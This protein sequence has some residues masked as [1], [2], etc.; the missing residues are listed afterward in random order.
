MSRLVPS[1]RSDIAPFMAMD[2]LRDARALERAGRRIVHM[3]LGE[4]GAP[5]PRLVREAAEAALRGGRIGYGEALGDAGLRARIAAHY[6]AR[7]GVDVGADRVVVTTGSSGGFM[8]ALLAAFDAGARIAVT[9]PGYPAYA[10]ILASLGLEAVPLPIGPATRFAP[11]AAMLEAAHREKKLDGALFMSPAN[12]TGAVIESEELA[13]ICAFCDEAGVVFVSDEIYHGLEYAAPAET[14]LRFTQSAIVVNSFSKYYA[15][16][17]WR[18]GWLVAPPAFMRPLERL[19]QSLAICAPTISQRA[20]LAAFD[21]TEELQENRAAYARNRALLLEKL[22]AMG[23]DGFAP[24]DGAFYVYADV[25]AFTADSLDFCRNMLHEA[26]VAAT[27]G[28]DFDPERGATTL[29]L[30]Y[31]GAEADIAEGVKRLGAWLSAKPR[32]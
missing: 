25:S 18:L 5:A 27:P 7:Y 26:G 10:N 32:R 20:A 11:T 4:P 16:T 13:R 19:Q 8:L 6:A 14:A 12:P 23:L 29:R 22:P 21:A 3:E 9:A 17:G 24:P 2:A 31:A 1:R 28:L 15:M 30:S